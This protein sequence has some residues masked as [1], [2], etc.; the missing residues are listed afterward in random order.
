MKENPVTTAFPSQLS[1][2]LYA[3]LQG[4][5]GIDPML[6]Q[7]PEDLALLASRRGRFGQWATTPVGKVSGSALGIGGLGITLLSFVPIIGI[8]DGIDPSELVGFA[9]CIAAS[10]GVTFGL[11]KTIS[12]RDEVWNAM[13]QPRDV[14]TELFESIQADL[15]EIG[16]T[17]LSASK[18]E[19]TF[20]TQKGT[21]VV[22]EDKHEDLVL[23]LNGSPMR[24]SYEN[25]SPAPMEFIT[26]ITG[27][28]VP[29]STTPQVIS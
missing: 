3:T 23:L 28:R 11:N 7:S 12:I 20:T 16:H 2:D 17:I 5:P 15:S 26:S 22:G 9:G 27:K 13:P 21:V 14:K 25:I 24:I 19:L 8:L 18:D 10:V 4:R 29:I 1:R 6:P